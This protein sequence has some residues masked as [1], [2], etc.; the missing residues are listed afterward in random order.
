MTTQSKPLSLSRARDRQ[1]MA[2]RL[3]AIA[4]EQ[5]ASVERCDSA[6]AVLL[7]LSVNGVRVWI[8]LDRADTYFLGNWCSE[9]RLC[10]SF[11]GDVGGPVNAYH[12]RKA[13][14]CVAGKDTA[15]AFEQFCKHI[16]Q[17]LAAAKEGAVFL[18]DEEQ[19]A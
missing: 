2:R 6:R 4:A 12:G 14:T 19:E 10:P 17:G 5:S 15:A 18:D 11:G 9:K 16:H 1:Q 3:E 13:T 8:D 7:T